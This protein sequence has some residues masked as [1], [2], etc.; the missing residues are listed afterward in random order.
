MRGYHPLTDKYSQIAKMNGGKRAEEFEIHKDDDIEIYDLASWTFVERDSAIQDFDGF[1]Q[2]Y[3]SKEFTEELI[4]YLADAISDGALE[5]GRVDTSY[6]LD[7]TV[8]LLHCLS[9]DRDMMKR[10]LRYMI[11]T[12]KVQKTKSGRLYN[13]SY[14]FIA[15][16]QAG[17][18]GDKFVALIKLED[19]V[20]L[21][22]GEFL[23]EK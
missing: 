8:C 6:Q 21:R 1:W 20:D 19:F 12:N 22:T 11:D 23:D 4:Q 5:S 13:I 15:Q 10:V 14:K 9:T 7:T 3:A 18:T 17:L 16:S 2:I